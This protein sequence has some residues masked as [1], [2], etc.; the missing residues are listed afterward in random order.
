DPIDCAILDLPH[1]LNG[2]ELKVD[3]YISQ[4]K[5]KESKWT[6]PILYE[7]PSSESNEHIKRTLH[8]QKHLTHEIDRLKGLISSLRV[9]LKIK[10]ISLEAQYQDKI[11]KLGDQKLK[12]QF[13]N[14]KQKV[15]ALEDNNKNLKSIIQKTELE[16][17]ILEPDY[18]EQLQYEK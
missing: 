15:D 6:K 14:L 2:N 10:L 12:E 11:A 8:S 16:N 7:Y 9:S 5:I 17:S 3:K 18:I 1:Y 13:S 4:E